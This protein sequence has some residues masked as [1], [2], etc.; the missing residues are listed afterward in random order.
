MVR[1]FFLL[2]SMLFRVSISRETRDLPGPARL[3]E[4][5]TVLQQL[6]WQGVGAQ[7]RRNPFHSSAD[8]VSRFNDARR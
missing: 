4:L 1:L 2:P 8:A 5:R 7:G 3:D 6:L